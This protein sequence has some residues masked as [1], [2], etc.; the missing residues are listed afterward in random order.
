MVNIHPDFMPK[1]DQ[2]SG[3]LK[4]TDITNAK[5]DDTNAKELATVGNFKR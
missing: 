3:A 2:V 4:C 1:S 5:N